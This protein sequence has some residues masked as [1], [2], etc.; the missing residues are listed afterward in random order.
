MTYINFDDR[1][2]ALSNISA[3]LKRIQE[4]IINHTDIQVT[5]IEQDIDQVVKLVC[6]HRNTQVKIEVNTI[7]RGIIKPTNTL[8]VIQTVQKEF[9]LFAEMSITS[10]GELFGGKICAALDR[11]HPRDLFDIFYLLQKGGI[12]TEIKQGFIAALLSHPRAIHEMLQPNLHNQKEAFTNQF[13]GMTDVPFTYEDFENSREMLVSAVQNM[14]TAQDK[15]FLISFKSGTPEWQLSDIDNLRAL[16]AI[17][18][19][20]LNIQ[21]LKQDDQTRHLSLSGKLK[22]CL[23]KT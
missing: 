22:D 19:K 10:Y 7:M 16:P 17:A 8:Q 3:A 9:G 5:A 15:A 6:K 4:Q 12:I 1:S 20:L 23:H 2:T 21:K 13:S 18:W 14:L 11:Q